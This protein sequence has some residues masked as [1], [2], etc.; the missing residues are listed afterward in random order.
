VP[1]LKA[2]SLDLLQP[3]MEFPLVFFLSPARGD[4]KERREIRCEA[5]Q[6]ELFLIPALVTSDTITQGEININFKCQPPPACLPA[7]GGPGDA[8]VAC[9]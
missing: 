9:L 8:Q 2:F 7:A 3:R 4:G 5:H 1:L 6:V